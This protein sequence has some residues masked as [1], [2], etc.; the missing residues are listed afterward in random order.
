MDKLLN[1]LGHI[2]GNNSGV[3]PD[4]VL[5]TGIADAGGLKQSVS[6]A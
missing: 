1:E 2:T 5:Q 3:Y 4:S 6:M